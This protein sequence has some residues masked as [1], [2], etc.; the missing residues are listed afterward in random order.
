[1]LQGIWEQPC[2]QIAQKE[3]PLNPEGLSSSSEGTKGPTGFREEFLVFHEA[4]GLKVF[5]GK[6][7]PVFTMM[8]PI[9]VPHGRY[10]VHHLSQQTG[11]PNTPMAS[12][13]RFCFKLYR[14]LA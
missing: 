8:M 5:Y 14:S 13:F 10:Q 6:S 11:Q 2:D 9:Y 7:S 4:Y 1:M 12:R 3:R